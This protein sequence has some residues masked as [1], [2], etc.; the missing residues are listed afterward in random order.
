MELP[1]VTIHTIIIIV[2]NRPYQEISNKNIIIICFRVA[3]LRVSGCLNIKS[4]I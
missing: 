3:K 4:T 2:N 1:I